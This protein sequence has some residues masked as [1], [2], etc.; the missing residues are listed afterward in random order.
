MGKKMLLPSK[1]L[2]AKLRVENGKI[3]RDYGTP[4]RIRNSVYRLLEEVV[5][6]TGFSRVDLIEKLI[7]FG[8]DNVEYVTTEEYR[9]DEIKNSDIK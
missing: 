5:E 7:I 2:D 1:T 6:E 4:V 8:L 9:A 3:N